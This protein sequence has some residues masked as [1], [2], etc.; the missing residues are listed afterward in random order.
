VVPRDL[1]LDEALAL[2]A[3]IAANGPLA[4]AATKRVMQA[5]LNQGIAGARAAAADAQPAVF[6]SNDAREGAIAFVEKREPVWTG[7]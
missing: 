5:A 4:V 6:G 3:A 2:A 7:T 1:L